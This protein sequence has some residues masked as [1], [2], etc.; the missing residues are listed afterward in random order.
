MIMTAATCLALNIFFEAR[1]E[2][3]DGQLAVAEVTL[4]RVADHRYPDTVC[5]V[6][7]E[8]KQ[9]SWT[10]DGVHDDPTRMSYLDQRA[11]ES[12]TE[13]ASG[14]L[15]GTTTKQGLTATHY[16]SVEVSPFWTKHYE[17]DGQ[18]GSHLFY[19]NETPYR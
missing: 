5:E 9:F 6:V 8:D 2:P 18:V 7:W 4:N 3:V 11:W 14:V 12:I 19:T 16:H 1:Q 15:D 13:L 10:H 17:Y